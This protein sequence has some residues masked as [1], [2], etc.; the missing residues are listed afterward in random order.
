MMILTK[1]TNYTRHAKTLVFCTLQQT[2]PQRTSWLKGKTPDW[3]VI[4]WVQPSK[5]CAKSQMWLQ[6]EA[7]EMRWLE[8]TGM[9]GWQ[10][11]VAAGSG[12]F[13]RLASSYGLQTLMG[14]AAE[15]WELN[16]EKL[17]DSVCLRLEVTKYPFCYGLWITQAITGSMWKG[18]TQAH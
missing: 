13:W 11:R 4:L 7:A 12:P 9:H 17:Q 18:T 2:T 10:E 8:S 15:F 6:L 5:F 1:W 16:S 3:A 14:M